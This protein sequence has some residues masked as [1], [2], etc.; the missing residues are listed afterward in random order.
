[1]PNFD[2]ANLALKT[3]CPNNELKMDDQEMPSTMVFI[4]AFKLK[5]V[6]N[7]DSTD[8]HP[9]FRIN[10]KEIPGFW[11]GKYQ[12]K[13]YNGR[14]YSLPGEDPSVNENMD[15]FVAKNKAKGAGW[16]EITNAEWAAIALWCH[17]NGCEPYGNNNYGKDSR[18]TSYKAI[19]TSLDNGKTGR[20]ATGTGPVSWSH[21]GTLAGVFD[22]NGNVWEWCTGLRLVNGE[23]QIIQDN[24]AAAASCDHSASSIEWKAIRASDGTLVTPD[25][26]GTT[27][28]TV[29]LDWVNGKWKYVTKIATK[30]SNGCN[31]KD[32]TA[33]SGFGQA[34]ILLLK[35]LALLPDTDLVGDGIDTTYGGDYFYANTNEAERCLV[36]GGRWHHG[37]L[38]GV[39]YASLNDPRSGVS[40]SIGG[41]SAF[42][43]N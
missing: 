21:D 29:K 8:I 35:S 6:L 26:S 19:P 42:V 33:D 11:V 32:I 39:F 3:I 15:S 22:M 31:F 36:R 14:A 27:V 10:G 28:G 18:E 40:S 34:T 12:T 37:A 25:G 4:P 13:H 43:E 1:M 24:N 41:R 17:K 7:T 16:H 38:A 9:A 20:V 5:D 23:V 30:T 2:A